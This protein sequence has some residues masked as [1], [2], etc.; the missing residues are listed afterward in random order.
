MLYV[1]MKELRADRKNML[2]HLYRQ[3]GETPVGADIY[4]ADE[5]S[6]SMSERIKRTPPTVNRRIKTS[7]D[8]NSTDQG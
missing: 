7:R 2:Q 5:M 8:S 6:G 4:E 1:L 3:H